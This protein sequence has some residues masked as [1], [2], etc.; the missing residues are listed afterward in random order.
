MGKEQDKRRCSLC[1]Y[2]ADGRFE[3]GHL[4]SIWLTGNVLNADFS[5]RQEN[6]LIFARNVAK[7]DF[8]DVTCYTPE[9]GGPGHV[10]PR[11]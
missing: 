3:G 10:A 6:H 11:L 8:V 9:C 5:L 1:G 2:T 4:P 7:C